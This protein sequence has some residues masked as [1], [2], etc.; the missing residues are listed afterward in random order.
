[1]GHRD[2]PSAKWIIFWGSLATITLFLVFV[3]LPSR[4]ATHRTQSHDV[5]GSGNNVAG[6]DI[7][8]QQAPKYRRA[9][10]LNNQGR[11]TPVVSSFPP[12]SSLMGFVKHQVKTENVLGYAEVGAEVNVIEEVRTRDPLG[13]T[14]AHVEI[15]SGRLKG[16]AGWINAATIHLIQLA[17]EKKAAK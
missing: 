5:Q 13:F 11:I 17:E 6:G 15:L 9:T 7:T 2:R 12:D 1:M 10:I 16:T 3:I 14:L 4:S 8:I